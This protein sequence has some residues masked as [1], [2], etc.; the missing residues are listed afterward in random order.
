MPG[1]KESKVWN[2]RGSQYW[3]DFEDGESVT[4]FLEIYV[5]WINIIFWNTQ[6]STSKQYAFAS[7]CITY[8]EE[9]KNY[10]LFFAEYTTISP[11]AKG[12]RTYLQESPFPYSLCVIFLD[13]TWTLAPQT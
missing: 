11:F 9:T 8:Q 13:L 2:N 6:L 10:P 5:S 3:D 1:K 7:Y 4:L 12:T